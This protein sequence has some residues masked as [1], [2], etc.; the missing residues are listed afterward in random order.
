MHT[1][2]IARLAVSALVVAGFVVSTAPAQAAATA[3]TAATAGQPC[4]AYQATVDR[5]RTDLEG[6]EHQL[7]GLDWAKQDADSQAEYAHVVYYESRDDYRGMLD[8]G[9]D[10]QSPEMV[11]LEQ[12][13]ASNKDAW[14]AAEAEYRDA[15]QAYDT[16]RVELTPQRDRSRSLLK[17]AQTRLATCLAKNA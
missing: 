6:I 8:D 13:V 5:H 12:Q 11:A 2:G 16:G 3:A 14:Q 17:R 9:D 1:R 15:R 7:E 10:P 4:A